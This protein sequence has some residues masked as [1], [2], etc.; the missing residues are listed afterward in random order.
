VP[1]SAD[2]Y[3]A[4]VGFAVS[5]TTQVN[6]TKAATIT[7]TGAL[8]CNVFSTIL[9]FSNQA[10]TASVP[11]VKTV[12]LTSLA[13]GANTLYTVGVGLTAY[14]AGFA[15]SFFNSGSTQSINN[16]SQAVIN[17]ISQASYTYSVNFVRSAGSPSNANFLGNG[18]TATLTMPLTSVM[19][20]G[21]FIN[22]NSS[23][24][25]AGQFAFVSVWES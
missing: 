10:G 18:T 6:E 5:T 24:S 7:F 8:S 19:N 11:N 1:S 4:G 3:D 20:A 2:L 12:K 23:S 9:L 21:D 15:D 14:V 25:A 22:I 16:Y 17:V 13:S